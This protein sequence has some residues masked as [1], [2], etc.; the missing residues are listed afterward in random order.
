MMRLQPRT[1]FRQVATIGGV[2][3]AT[4]YVGGLY[5]KIVKSGVTT[6]HRYYILPGQ[7]AVAVQINRSS[8][9]LSDLRYLFR[10][11]LG[12]EFGSTSDERR[13]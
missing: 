5:E 10:D 13:K 6:F 11:H 3:E 12:N 2:T 4:R 1:R 7:E 9:D 8:G